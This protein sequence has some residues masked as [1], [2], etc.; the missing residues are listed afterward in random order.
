MVPAR[1]PKRTTLPFGLAGIRTASTFAA[2]LGDP[3]EGNEAFRKL[4]MKKARAAGV[5]PN[6][7]RYFPGLCPKGE[8]MS[9]K[10]WVDEM[11]AKAQI[12]ATCER[13]GWSAEGDVNVKGVELDQP[14]PGEKPYRVSDH[15]IEQELTETLATTGE[16][17]GMEKRAEMKEDLHVARAGKQ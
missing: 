11:D 13:N 4:A 5:N 6:G 15:L 8:P 17:P 9:P 7:K 3:F 10:A 16:R 12:R 2:G 14:G 1:I